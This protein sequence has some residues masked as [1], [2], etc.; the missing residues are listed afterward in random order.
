[1]IA[2]F[3]GAG[4]SKFWGLPLASEVMDIESIYHK[5]HKWQRRLLKE[6]K[7]LWET[8]AEQHK[9][10]VDDFARILHDSDEDEFQKFVAFLALRV[11]SE[12]WRI[13]TAHATRWAIGDHVRKQ[14][15][16]PPQYRLFLNA[17][18]KANLLG[19]VTTNYDIVVEKLLG[20]LASGRLGGFH[21]G[22]RGEQ[23]LG[24]HQLSS[25]N[26]YPPVTV[27]GKVPLLKLHGSLNWEL[28]AEGTVVKHVDCRPSR[29]QGNKK[30]QTLLLPPGDS[31][32][33]DAL[34]PT[35]D[36]A[37]Q[38]LSNSEVWVLCG[39]SLPEYDSHIRHLLAQSASSR[40]AKVCV[41]DIKPAR[42][43]EKLSAILNNGKHT[44]QLCEYPGIT[45]EFDK[46]HERK[47]ATAIVSA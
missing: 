4:F 26:F 12:H 7:H 11:S 40:V 39:Y 45:Q 42:V 32:M 22:M 29:G 24:H 36:H 38:V 41:C 28:S 16:I 27:K 19:I 13:G 33:I 6:V 3:L 46:E 35:W 31:P 15:Q 5:Q 9:G 8:K 37:R 18:S 20:P 34:R 21:Y 10:V 17:I 44:V 30:Y 2:L 14:K 23:L 47:L 1:M 25:Q 43:C